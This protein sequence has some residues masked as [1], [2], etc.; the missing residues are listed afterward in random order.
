MTF[1]TEKPSRRAALGAIVS[2]PASGRVMDDE[3]ELANV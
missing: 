1:S 3:E 2:V